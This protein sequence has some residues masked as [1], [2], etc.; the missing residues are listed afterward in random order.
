MAG[1]V[2]SSRGGRAA[3]PANAAKRPGLPW[4][5]APG[6][7]RRL[8]RNL[9]KH[10]NRAASLLLFST[11]FTTPSAL[12]KH[13]NFP[14]LLWSTSKASLRGKKKK[15]VGPFGRSVFVWPD[16]PSPDHPIGQLPDVKFE[17][18][19]AHGSANRRA[20]AGPPGHYGAICQ[21]NQ[22]TAAGEVCWRP[23]TTAKGTK[24]IFCG[25]STQKQLSRSE[26][27]YG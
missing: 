1:G 18:L 5:A 24:A 21:K 23:A 14:P 27:P 16:H 17:P 19:L 11:T 25:D 9:Q 8:A 2:D 15:V 6:N 4:G 7:Q 12:L 20:K 3:P 22:E 13:L 26:F 10:R